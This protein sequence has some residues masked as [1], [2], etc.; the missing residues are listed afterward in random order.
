MKSTTF[1]T[2]LRKHI[3]FITLPLLI[4]APLQT[5]LADPNSSVRK[6]TR[7]KHIIPGKKA[8]KLAIIAAVKEKYKGRILTVRKRPAY[9][10]KNCHHVKMIDTKGEFLLI[11][12]TCKNEKKKK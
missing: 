1:L 2:G 11:K 5:A 9:Y 3:L 12:V 8:S 7:S 4:T 6:I 10:G